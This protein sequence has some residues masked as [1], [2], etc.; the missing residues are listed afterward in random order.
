MFAR[1]S[2]FLSE[3]GQVIVFVSKIRRIALIWKGA[4][5]VLNKGVRAAEEVRYR[6]GEGNIVLLKMWR[7]KK[8]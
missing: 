3:E 2:I 1:I 8:F 5:I 6:S 4:S 7:L